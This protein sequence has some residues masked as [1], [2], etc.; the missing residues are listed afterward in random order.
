V[1]L[2]QNAYST[3]DDVDLFVGG[4]YE[5]PVPGGIVGPTFACII[6]DQFSRLKYGD[7]YFYDLIGEPHN[8]SPG[9]YLLHLWG[10]AVRTFYIR[11]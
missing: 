6:G 7:S 5:T 10:L 4:L 11:Y 3:V 9:M 1:Y 8:F 2:L